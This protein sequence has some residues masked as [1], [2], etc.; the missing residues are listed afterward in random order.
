MQCHA[1]ELLLYEFC[2]N[3]YECTNNRIYFI[4]YNLLLVQLFVIIT[5]SGASVGTTHECRREATKR[6]ATK[7]STRAGMDS[8]ECKGTAEEGKGILI[9]FL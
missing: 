8:A 7:H 9:Q 2:G 3:F 4:S 1:S 6:P 5:K